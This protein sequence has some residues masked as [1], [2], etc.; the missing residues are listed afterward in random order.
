MQS[1]DQAEINSDTVMAVRVD[2]TLG[3][4]GPPGGKGRGPLHENSLQLQDMF[5]D[6]TCLKLG[7]V[8]EEGL[9]GGGAASAYSILLLDMHKININKYQ[10]PLKSHIRCVKRLPVP[11]LV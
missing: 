9:G 8:Q 5:S 3:P 1:I 6:P 10:Q 7:Q 4:Q 11:E 2:P